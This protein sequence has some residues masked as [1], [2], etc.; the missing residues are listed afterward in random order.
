MMLQAQLFGYAQGDGYQAVELLCGVFVQRLDRYRL[1]AGAFRPLPIP[2]PPTREQTADNPEEAA[3]TVAKIKLLA[4]Y[5]SYD[6]D[7]GSEKYGKEFNAL[8]FRPLGKMFGVGLKYARY[9]ARPDVPNETPLTPIYLRDVD[10][11][12]LWLQMKL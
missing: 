9:D 12:W 11:F 2:P 1:L 10:K 4:R 5:H 3:K 6:R 8:G 7:N